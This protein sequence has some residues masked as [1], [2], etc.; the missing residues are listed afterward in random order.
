MGGQSKSPAEE[1]TTTTTRARRDKCIPAG[2]SWLGFWEQPEDTQT[3]TLQQ[4][5]GSPVPINS[6]NPQGCSVLRGNP[7]D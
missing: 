2:K 7:T 1:Q 3:S 5:E 6:L 4:T